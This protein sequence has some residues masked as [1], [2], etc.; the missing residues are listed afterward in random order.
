MK[1]SEL[2]T[3]LTA[4]ERRRLA[5][6][7]EGIRSVLVDLANTRRALAFYAD[8]YEGMRC[9]ACDGKE[10]TG[11]NFMPASPGDDAAMCPLENMPRGKP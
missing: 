4:D 5:E 8:A 6:D 1:H 2:I 9:A 10:D 3:W 7:G 11:H